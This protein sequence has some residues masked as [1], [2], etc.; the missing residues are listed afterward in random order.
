MK[1]D[2]LEDGIA[3]SSVIDVVIL[4]TITLA[5]IGIMLLYMTPAITDMQD[6]AKSQKV[7]QAFTVFDSRTSKTALGESPTQNTKFSIMGGNLKVLGDVGSYKE[8][9]IMIISLSENSSW[10][11]SFYQRRGVWNAWESYQHEPDF[12]GF[13]TPMGKVQYNSGDRSIAYEGGGVWSKYP[14]GGTTMVSP[15]EFHYNGETLNLPIMKINGNTTLSGK[16]DANINIRSSNIPAILYPNTSINSNF[17]N[18]LSCDKLIIYINSEFYEGWAE[19][20]QTL[21]STTVTLD[22]RNQTAVIELDT[23]PQM[24][25]F[26]LV[27]S[28]F[29]VG[30]LNQ[31]NPEPIYDLEFFLENTGNDAADFNP[32]GMTFTA[33]SG[34]KTFWYELKKKDKLFITVTYKDASVDKEEIWTGID[35]IR[36]NTSANNNKKANTTVDLV[37]GA[38]RLKYDTKDTEFSWDEVSSTTMT[39]N[40]TISKGEIQSLNDVTQHYMKL[41]AMNGPFVF[42][43]GGQYKH[44]DLGKSALTL[45]YDAGSGILTY[46]HITHNELNTTVG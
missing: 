13:M 12:T 21:T 20:A 1:N 10:H 3:V 2:V 45:N 33:T 22:H 25:T 27:R 46:L 35:E 9:R 6:M 32:A 19:Y 11:D 37:S 23:K 39:P 38:Y 4:L 41:M 30:K 7:E 42:Y 34:T 18:P 40:L 29:K 15:P 26:P 8:S 24:G 31:S 5:S 14:G 17:V 44:V 43:L 28:S 16:T 36:V